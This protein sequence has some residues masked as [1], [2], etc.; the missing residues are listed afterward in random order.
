M[1]TPHGGEKIHFWNWHVISAS[2]ILEVASQGRSDKD[3]RSRNLFIFSPSELAVWPLA[4]VFFFFAEFFN[5]MRDVTKQLP[6]RY[7]LTNFPCPSVPA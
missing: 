1:N 7:Q 6:R 2:Q 3:G 5:D 4:V